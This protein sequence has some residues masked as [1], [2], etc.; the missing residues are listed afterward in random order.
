MAVADIATETDIDA[1]T[2]FGDVVVMEGGVNTA[3]TFCLSMN[4]VHHCITEHSHRWIRN[5]G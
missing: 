4:K 1:L 3:G 5:H 2:A